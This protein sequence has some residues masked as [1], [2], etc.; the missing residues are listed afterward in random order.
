MFAEGSLCLLDPSTETNLGEGEGAGHS[1]H[2]NQG[3]PQQHTH[4]SP[5]D[6]GEFRVP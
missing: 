6:D 1:H 3:D 2:E 5:P 4:D